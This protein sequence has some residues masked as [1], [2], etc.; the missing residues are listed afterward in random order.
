VEVEKLVTPLGHDAD[1]ILEEGN[2]DEES[3]DGWEVTAGW[4]RG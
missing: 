4:I 3:A 2:D 1:G